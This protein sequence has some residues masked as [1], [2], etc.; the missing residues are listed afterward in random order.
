[1]PTS[2]IFITYNTTSWLMST[3]FV[4]NYW[5]SGPGKDIENIGNY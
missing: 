1:M 3:I 5:A 2:F 4:S